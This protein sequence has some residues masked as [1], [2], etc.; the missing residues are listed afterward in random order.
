MNTT[1]MTARVTKLLLALAVGLSV[2]LLAQASYKA[3]SLSG[4]WAR[5]T[6]AGAVVRPSP[7][8]V[9]RAVFEQSAVSPRPVAQVDAALLVG[10]AVHQAS[11]GRLALPTG[12]RF[13]IR[14]VASR[15]GTLE[16]YAVNPSGA[17]S[18]EP[19]WTGAAQAGTEVLTPA[20]RL[21]GTQGLET[22]RVVLKV[23]GQGVVA[24]RKIQ[25]WHLS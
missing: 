24:L 18:S 11:Q 2:G 25:V 6:G 10:G 5:L 19:L 23:P 3:G 20:L 9:A 4:G 16:L 12:T 7:D 22:L 14:L 13:Q 21:E 17:S 1:S 15:S 8:D